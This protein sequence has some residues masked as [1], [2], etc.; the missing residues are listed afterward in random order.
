MPKIINR[1]NPL[2]SFG[3]WLHENP[4][5]GVTIAH[6]PHMFHANFRIYTGTDPKERRFIATVGHQ[7]VRLFTNSV[8]ILAAIRTKA[9]EYE[10]LVQESLPYFFADFEITII[11]FK[12]FGE[13]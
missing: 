10:A 11:L 6:E 1:R 3:L 4:P 13:I 9:E 12:P 7:T 5:P 2:T 8:P